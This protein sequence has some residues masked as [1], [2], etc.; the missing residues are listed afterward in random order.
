MQPNSGPPAFGDI[1]VQVG[2][3]RPGWRA[4]FCGH[5]EIS[6]RYGGRSRAA[7]QAS[8]R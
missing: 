5:L 3:S 1:I 4:I 7:I 6:D 2:K 8:A